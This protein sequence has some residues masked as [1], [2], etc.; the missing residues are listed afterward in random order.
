M[1]AA[2]TPQTAF[3]DSAWAW[4]L[5]P[6][7]AKDLDCSDPDMVQCRTC[8]M[9]VEAKRRAILENLA[10]P[11]VR[12]ADDPDRQK[13]QVVLLQRVFCASTRQERLRA[14]RNFEASLLA[15]QFDSEAAA[16]STAGDL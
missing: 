15:A 10:C 6:H 9:R 2:G 13:A 11:R 7:T 14:V 1:A 5:R 16:S 8:G 4:S 3:L 12:L